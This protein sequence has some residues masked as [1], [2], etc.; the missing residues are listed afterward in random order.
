M[1]DMRS[2]LRK[3]LSDRMLLSGILFLFALGGFLIHKETKISE[4]KRDTQIAENASR[5]TQ[6]FFDPEERKLRRATSVAVREMKE[7]KR[8]ALVFPVLGDYG[9]ESPANCD[10]NF[11]AFSEDEVG[12]FI[13]DE[14]HIKIPR[15]ITDL[16][17]YGTDRRIRIVTQGEV[18]YAGITEWWVVMFDADGGDE[19]DKL[20]LG[21]A[22]YQS[23]TPIRMSEAID[24]M[25]LENDAL[26]QNRL[27]PCFRG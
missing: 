3:I 4:A 2:P 21:F 8:A 5:L 24:Q 26:V 10:N 16:Y 7:Q 11:I 9:V 19:R 1:S 22:M 20:E 6:S 17:E 18:T 14:L 13:A 15:S 12:V 27:F 23:P 25:I